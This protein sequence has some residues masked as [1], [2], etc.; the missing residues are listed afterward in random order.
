M[1]RLDR[2]IKRVA[3][4][5]GLPAVSELVRIWPEVVGETIAANAWPAQLNRKRVLQVNTSSA[6]WA[7]ELKHLA[8]QILAKLGQALAGECPKELHFIPGP[9]PAA[10]RESDSAPAENRPAASAQERAQG[11]KLA[12]VI[13]DD[14]LRALVARAA[15]ASLAQSSRKDAP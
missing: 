10:G 8:P 15:A 2:E 7:F 12:A 4:R 14:E 9:V 6:T 13:A 5:V 11:E 1:D 3:R